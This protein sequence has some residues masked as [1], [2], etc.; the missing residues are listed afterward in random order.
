MGKQRE[1]TEEG[2][3]EMKPIRRGVEEEHE[4]GQGQAKV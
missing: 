4:G 3:G 1:K 2:E